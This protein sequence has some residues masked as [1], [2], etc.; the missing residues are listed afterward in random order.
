MCLQ[1]VKI[2]RAISHLSPFSDCNWKCVPSKMFRNRDGDYDPVR[3]K[4]RVCLVFILV[5][6]GHGVIYIHFDPPPV[7][8]EPARFIVWSRKQELTARAEIITRGEPAGPET[9]TVHESTEENLDD[10]YL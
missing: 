8:R 2:E 5:F 3:I 4:R 7:P 6:S 9:G 10:R 1:T